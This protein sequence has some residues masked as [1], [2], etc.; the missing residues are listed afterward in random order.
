MKMT[1]D[2][3]WLKY[4]HDENRKACSW[5]DIE[6]PEVLVGEKDARAMPI[7]RTEDIGMEGSPLDDGIPRGTMICLLVHEGRP[8]LVNTEG[9]TYARYIVPA[10]IIK[11]IEEVDVQDLLG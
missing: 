10:R 5:E 11:N 7:F 8:Y 9:F 2:E 3:L 1:H 6:G 4:R